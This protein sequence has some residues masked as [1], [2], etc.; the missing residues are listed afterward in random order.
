[1]RISVLDT[2]PVP[3]GATATEAV[4]N[5]IDLARH[6][7]ALGLTRYWLAEHHNAG[8]LACP[9]PE[10]MMAAVAAAT[11]TIR[12]GSGGV[13]LPNHSPLKVAENFRVL[14]ALYPGRIDLGIGRAAGTDPKTALALRQAKELLGAEQFP[15]QLEELMQFLHYEPDP[16]QRF[17]PIKATPIGVSPPPIFVLGSGSDS[18]RL[19]AERGLGYA[20]AHHIGPDGYAEAMTLYRSSFKAPDP[21][22]N[23]GALREP[24]AILA[25]AAA[26]A[27]SEEHAADLERAASLGWLR[28]GQ[29]LRDLG[30]PSI[31]EARAYAF[32]ADEEVF[33]ASGSG[34]SLIGSPERVADAI[35]TMAVTSRSD[36]IMVMTGIHDHDERKRSYER[37]ARSLT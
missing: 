35:R 5:T 31:E 13:M 20:Y 36:E 33:R 17:G 9:A 24:Y 14:G 21:S 30:A 4:R 12:V 26:C 23:P 11:A 25:V 2:T 29:G 22:Q 6:A 3:S 18:A 37:L 32:D 27:R 16:H 28:F 7:E 10:I 34:R 19:A 15:A 1:M 8:S